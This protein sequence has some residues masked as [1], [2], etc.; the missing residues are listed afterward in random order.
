MPY[1]VSIKELAPQPVMGVRMN[2]SMATLKADIGQAYAE[3]F[4]L[5]ATTGGQWV[6]PPMAIYFGLEFSDDNIDFEAAVPVRE[7]IADSGR[8][9]GRVL[10]GGPAACTLHPGPYSELPGAYQSVMDYIQQNGL[11]AGDA[12]REIYLTNP[13][14]VK[15]EAEHR[16]EVIWPVGR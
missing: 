1:E 16:T 12:C 15:D 7:L 3:I 13:A 11:T 8:V 4:G 10:P 6:G 2:S 9:K 5:L 14:E